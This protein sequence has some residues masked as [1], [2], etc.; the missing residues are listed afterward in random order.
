MIDTLIV[1]SRFLNYSA[2]RKSEFII[3]H[4]F[5][6]VLDLLVE[7]ALHM[8]VSIQFLRCGAANF[9]SLIRCEFLLWD[10]FE[11]SGR[12]SLWSLQRDLLI[13]P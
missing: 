13:R 7:V 8:F 5:L 2:L 6:M 10:L 1:S 3:S 4:L 9:H 11:L 12:L